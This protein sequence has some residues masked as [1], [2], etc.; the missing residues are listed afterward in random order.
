MGQALRVRKAEMAGKSGLTPND[1]M[2]AD[3]TILIVDDDEGVREFLSLALQENGFETVTAAS[4]A[5]ALEQAGHV[6]FEVVLAGAEGMELIKPLK[7]LPPDIEVI[8]MTGFASMES[9]TAA[10]DLGATGY[11]TK[12]LDLRQVLTKVSGSVERRTLARRSLSAPPAPT[13]WSA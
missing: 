8:M 11:I 3:G 13:T 9:A 10:L 7:R 2:S 5:D 6:E 1:G 4:G 12:P